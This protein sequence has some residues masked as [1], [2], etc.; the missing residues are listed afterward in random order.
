MTLPILDMT[1]WSILD[2]ELAIDGIRQLRDAV[3]WLQNQPRAELK[4][5][6]ASGAAFVVAIDEDWLAHRLCDMVERLERIR[7]TNQAHEDRRIRLLVMY[8]ADY[9]PAGEPLSDLLAMI[10]AQR[11]PLAA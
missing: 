11:Q 6:I 8:Y 5:G 2:F 7:F 3:T 10:E 1:A 9:G 4:T